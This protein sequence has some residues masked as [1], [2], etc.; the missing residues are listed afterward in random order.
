MAQVKEGDSVTVHYTGKLDDGEVFD[1]SRERDP[2]TFK[3]GA[4]QVIPGFENGVVG[5]EVGQSKTV[6]IPPDEGY[7]EQR[8][9]LFVK[10]HRADFPEDIE[11]EVG[12]QL[13]MKR[14]DGTPVNVMVSEVTAEDVTLN[15]NHP[16]AGKTLTFEIELMEI[17]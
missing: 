12:Q 11:P 6:E 4:G 5:M 1:S 7:G 16:L 3:V 10:V 14:P 17:G 13:Q 9:E 8:N 2:F 15:A